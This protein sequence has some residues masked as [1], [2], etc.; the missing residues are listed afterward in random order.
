MVCRTRGLD[1]TGAA[2][3]A[4]VVDVEDTGVGTG[5]STN[6][7]PGCAPADDPIHTTDHTTAAAAS[8]TAIAAH[9]P[10]TTPS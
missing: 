3:A 8:S 6:T 5:G 7:G 10:L 2:V 4:E 1:M 9:P